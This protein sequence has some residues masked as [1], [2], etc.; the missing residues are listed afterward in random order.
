[1]F[2]RPHPYVIR[3]AATEHGMLAVARQGRP[4]MMNVQTN[5]VTAQRMD[6][7]RRTLRER[8]M[9][10]AAVAANVEQCWVWR[11]VVVAETDGEAERI[12]IPAFEAMHDFR[13]AMRR[14]VYDEQGVSIVPM[15][16][17]GAAPAARMVVEHS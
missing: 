15:P 9:D 5:A 11:N 7:Y 14:R 17:P 6:L 8:G 4:F 3:A 13:T 12:A 2:T 16:A 1:S 10:E